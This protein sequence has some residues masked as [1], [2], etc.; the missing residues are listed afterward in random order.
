MTVLVTG[1]NGQLGTALRQIAPEGW[2]FSDIVG[3]GV[4][5]LDITDSAAVKAAVEEYGIDV[6]VNCAGYTN[7]EGAED[8]SA[9][10][11]LLNGTAPGIL[12]AAIKEKGGLIVHISTDYVFGGETV[13]EP[14]KEDANPAPISVYG[15]SKLRGE[16]AVKASGADYVILRTAWMHS[17]WGKNFVK[18]MIGLTSTRDSLKVVSDQTGTPTYAPD[19]ADAI[20]TILNEYAAGTPCCGIYNYTDEGSTTWYHFACEIAR[21]SGNTACEITPCTSA[22]FPTKAQRPQYSVLDKTLVK[23]TFGLEIPCW[24][25]SLHRCISAILQS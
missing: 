16:E 15:V 4:L 14:L 24:E 8:N 1:A 13:S 18:T 17:P 22:G 6:I 9:D 11:M 21:L 25:E 3:E 23:E 20:L 2:V 19:L 12:A 5:H 10:A 7:V